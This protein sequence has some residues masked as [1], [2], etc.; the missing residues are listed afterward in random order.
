MALLGTITIEER[1]R[2]SDILK[3]E[4]KMGKAALAF[5]TVQHTISSKGVA[6]WSGRGGPDTTF[7]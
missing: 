4:N 6:Q 7:R 3:L 5:L 2:R 1:P